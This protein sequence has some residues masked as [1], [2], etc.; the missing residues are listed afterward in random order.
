MQKNHEKAML[1]LQRLLKT[2]N[3][4]N[5][6]EMQAFMNKHVVGQKIQIGR[7]HV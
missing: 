2:Q 6:E 4:N 1:D 5:I 3:F 7:A